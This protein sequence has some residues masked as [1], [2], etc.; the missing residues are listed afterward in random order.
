MDRTELETKKIASPYR[1]QSDDRMEAVANFPCK[2]AWT[3]V[4]PNLYSTAVPT[5]L[6]QATP[7]FYLKFYEFCF[8]LEGAAYIIS[9]NLVRHLIFFV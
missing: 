4:L 9:H 6:L 8:V 2:N 7:R 3:L 1:Y 5:E